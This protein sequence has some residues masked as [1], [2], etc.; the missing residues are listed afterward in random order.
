MAKACYNDLTWGW[1]PEFESCYND[2]HASFGPMR[3][4]QMADPNCAPSDPAFWLLLAFIDMVWEKYRIYKQ[5]KNMRETEYPKQKLGDSQCSLICILSDDV[6]L[7]GACA[8]SF[9]K[10]YKQNARVNKKQK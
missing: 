10:P 8:M 5:G 2:V 4:V 7:I 1:D 9:L 6:P 3:D